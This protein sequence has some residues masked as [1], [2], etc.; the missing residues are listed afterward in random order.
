[1]DKELQG[2]LF[3]ADIFDASPKGDLASMEHPLFA[4]KAG[5]R[6]IRRYQRGDVFVEVQPGAHGLATIH[7]KDLWIHAIS[8][9][10]AGLNRGDTISRVVRFTA[11]DLLKS[12]RRGTSGR[13]YER[14]GKAL[15][16]LAGTR[17]V[18][19]AYTGGRRTKRGFGLLDEFEIV[20]RHPDDGRMVAIEMTLPEWLYRAVEAREC[21]TLSRD[22]FGIRKP[23]DRRI[24]ELA[25]KHCGKQGRWAVGIDTL[26][27][28]SGSRSPL[29]K[30]RHEIKAL[31]ES[32]S[33][34]DYRIEYDAD[35]DRAVFYSRTTKGGQAQ[36]SDL[37]RRLKL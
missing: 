35:R 4:L 1:M 9:L 32:R 26:Y 20:E 27:Q 36:L 23:L 17:V 13:S 10:T 8:Q 14:L 18:T 30:F 24:Y 12:A 25:R 34:P 22:Y 6:E 21:L 2:D 19:N 15:E 28:K 5:D 29:K 11:Y 3:V 31:A 7:D 33:L 16:R 37:K